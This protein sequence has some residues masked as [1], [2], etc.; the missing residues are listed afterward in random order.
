ML[1]F[2]LC[3]CTNT[4]TPEGT[5]ITGTVDEPSPEDGPAIAQDDPATEDK[6]GATTDIE[7]PPMPTPAG[8]TY[9]T[10]VSYGTDDIDTDE[11]TTELY[12]WADG[13][14]FFSFRQ[15]SAENSYF[16]YRET[17]D[18]SWALVGGTLRLTKADTFPRI[19]YLGNF[20]QDHLTITYD[21]V[22][23]GS[24]EILM[25]QA[26]LPPY[27]AQWDMPDMFG[28]WRLVSYRDSSG[29]FT[30]DNGIFSTGDEDGRYIYSELSI[31]ASLA[32]DFQLMAWEGSEMEGVQE[33]ERYLSV[34]HTNG[35]LWNTCPNQAWYA[36]FSGGSGSE[37]PLRA[38]YA[39]GKLLL[40][41]GDAS[42]TGAFPSSF[43][44]EYERLDID[45]QYDWHEWGEWIGQYSFYEYA[46]PDQNILYN[47]YI[48]NEPGWPFLSAYIVVDGF[49]TMVRKLGWVMG[50]ANYIE[51]VF[52]DYDQG[53]MDLSSGNLCRYGEII[54][55]FTRKGSDFYTSWGTLTP[56]LT[57]NHTPGIYFEPAAH[58]PVFSDSGS[59]VDDIPTIF[60]FADGTGSHL[61]V[62][63]YEGNDDPE[64]CAEQARYTLA[65]GP[66]GD[67]VPIHFIGWQGETAQN[68]HRD[69]SYNFDNLPGYIYTAANEWLK[70]DATYALTAERSLSDAL[71]KLYSPSSNTEKQSGPPMM[72]P[73]IV[74]S[75]SA[76]KGRGVQWAELLSITSEGGQIGLVLYERQDDDMLFSIVYLDG[77]Q[78]LFWDNKATYDEY[79]TWRVD[80]GDN[81]GN[82]KPL[83]LARMEDEG[84]VLAL[85]WGAPEGEILVVLQEDNGRFVRSDDYTF[86]RYWSP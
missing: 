20:E 59:A 83:Y 70:P 57:Y 10:A 63:D 28:T 79:S 82:L 34:K 67:L 41:K 35:A 65:V 62:T 23:T 61:I 9:W 51:I 54:L 45:L 44:A 26:D 69:T 58:V 5:G 48:T 29:A 68:S 25:E 18:C 53:D 31:Y 13:A 56:M 16:G 81:P 36:D 14:G 46:P 12:L 6:P 37:T 30:S 66:Y 42:S 80:M 76:L 32:T 15:V 49:Q 74:S 17:F 2:S 4:K 19:V 78:T 1:I 50:N 84:L 38:T 7:E 27:G 73:G 39:D 52:S 64:L 24:I 33:T 71:I 75:L 3:A 47:I 21:G 43:T 40:S 85:T 60:G 11:F 8:G 72:N 22:F 86:G 55:T 77:Q